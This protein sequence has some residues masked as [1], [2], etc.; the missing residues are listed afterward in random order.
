M[1]WWLSEVSPLALQSFPGHDATGGNPADHDED[2][3]MAI[4]VKWQSQG[5][6]LDISASFAIVI[7]SSDL[8][9]AHNMFFLIVFVKIAKC[10]CPFKTKLFKFLHMCI[11]PNY[12]M[13]FVQLLKCILEACNRNCL[14]WLDTTF[15]VRLCCLLL[16]FSTLIKKVPLFH[17][18]CLLSPALNSWQCGL[19]CMLCIVLHCSL[20]CAVER[21][22]ICPKY[23]MYLSKWQNVF[24]Q[25]ATMVSISSSRS[26][27]CSP[28][29]WLPFLN[30]SPLER[31]WI[32]PSFK[33]AF[34]GEFR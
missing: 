3:E 24:V 15:N 34:A 17:P 21:H 14:A 28:I 7:A 31:Y 30:C 16:L 9:K 27:K 33:I 6:S 4:L 13:Y 22:C 25:I 11:C 29:Y 2:D 8:S 26:H 32:F 20:L 19:H 10:I 23:K 18:H 5:Q 1:Q 12:N